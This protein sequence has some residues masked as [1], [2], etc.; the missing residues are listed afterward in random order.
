MIRFYT[1]L[2]SL[3]LIAFYPGRDVLYAQEVDNV[4]TAFEQARELAFEGEREE[5][6]KL[7]RAILEI[8]PGYQDVRILIARTY[9]WDGRYDDAR[10]ELKMVLDQDPDYKDA[11]SASIDN[12]LWSENPGRAVEIAEAATRF[13]PMDESLLLKS[14]SAHNAAGEDR[15][16]LQV[17]DKIDQINPASEPADRLRRRIRMTGLNYTMTVSYTYD[18]FSEVFDPWKKSYIQLSRKTPIGSVIGRVNYADRFGSNGFQPE[19]DFYP[20]IANGLYGYLNAGYTGNSLYPGFRFGSELYK[21]LPGG[22][23][24]SL[25]IRYLKFENSDVTIFTGAL[26]KY[27]GNWY[28]S[29]RPYV[30]PSS[31]G[32]S[33]S[34]NLTVRRYLN[35]PENYITLRGGFGFSP[36]E[37][38]F[39]DVSG[40]VFLVH[41]Q[42]IGI[43]LF[44]ALHYSFALFG[45]ADAARQE[46]Q[47][48][49]GRYIQVYTFNF[50]AQVKF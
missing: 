12:E 34:I 2:L 11:L 27:I 10:Q 21:R 41:S 18:W 6:R 3:L 45:S 43:D 14:A 13:H 33:R 9:S 42:F 26:T 22:F 31:V 49:P 19:I 25:G 48:D 17:L 37:R 4:D 32:N 8:S 24:T 16:A 23:E 40:D 38:R 35:G 29:A 20:S 28:F 50:G 39:Q 1:L 47:F 5:A 36:E 30:T 7:A 15:K 46:L 44:K